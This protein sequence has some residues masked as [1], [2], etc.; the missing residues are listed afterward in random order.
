M[1]NSLIESSRR[2]D[3]RWAAPFAFSGSRHVQ[4]AVG[5]G[6]N[7]AAQRPDPIAIPARLPA[8]CHRLAG[9]LLCLALTGLSLPA[10]ASSPQ[11]WSAYAQ[12]VLQACTAASGLL[13]PKPA[14]ERLDLPG[15]QDGLVSVLM[16]EGVVPQPHMQG[17]RGLELCLYDSATRRARVAEADRLHR[18][19]HQP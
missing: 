13:H 17:R 19:L 2:L 6:Q 14:G 3:L 1:P 5:S 12:Q 15:G 4:A 8:L 9:S 11:A 18:G 7:Q 10:R 16:L